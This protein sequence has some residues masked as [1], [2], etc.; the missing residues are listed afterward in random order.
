MSS[1]WDEA[2]LVSE[3]PKKD[4]WAEAE[5]VQQPQPQPKKN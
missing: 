5:E 3:E 2:E 4:I 1:I